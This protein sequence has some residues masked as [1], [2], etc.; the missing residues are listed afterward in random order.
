MG[1]DIY[2]YKIGESVIYCVS[3]PHL[4][5]TLNG[6]SIRLRETMSELLRFLI[7][8]AYMTKV[9][10]KE[11]MEEV[12]ECRGLR[13]SHQRLWQAV[14]TLEKYLTRVGMVRKLTCRVDGN[15]YAILNVTI[16]SLYYFGNEE[17]T[18]NT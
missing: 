6:Q 17:L 5:N 2:G 16:S 7:D 18:D 11:I 10:D 1:F 4:V 14:N 8:N 12:F 15:G 13:C 3:P 9:N